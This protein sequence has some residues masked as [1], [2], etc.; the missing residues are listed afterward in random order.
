M[1]EFVDES[2]DCNFVTLPDEVSNPLHTMMTSTQHLIALPFTNE[3]LPQSKGMMEYFCVASKFQSKVI[4]L[5][6]YSN[7][8][9]CFLTKTS[10]FMQCQEL[11]LFTV[12]PSHTGLQRSWKPPE[13]QWW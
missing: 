12:G 11:G 13:N 3:R 4:N 7:S 2:G 6:F 10:L 1:I 5:H 9:C 8:Q